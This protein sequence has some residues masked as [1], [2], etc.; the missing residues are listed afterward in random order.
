MENF[1]PT[2][3]MAPGGP[4][5]VPVSPGD[6]YTT[7]QLTSMSDA[8]SRKLMTV[9][10]SD[11]LSSAPN[12]STGTGDICFY[13]TS[14][15]EWVTLSDR[16]PVTTSFKAYILALF[17]R[18]VCPVMTP[19]VS[20]HG[21][22]GNFTS[23]INGFNTGTGSGHTAYNTSP[24]SIQVITSSPGTT[25]TGSFKGYPIPGVQ[26]AYTL[27]PV[28]SFGIV[29]SYRPASQAV[30][31]AGVDNWHWR[32]GLQTP[33]YT[34]SAA[35]QA[36][37]IG[38]VMDDQNALGLGA[39]GSTLWSV[40]RL[41]ST[42][43]LWVDSL[44]NPTSDSRFLIIT[45]EPTGPGARQCLFEVSSSPD[46]STITTHASQNGSFSTAVSNALLPM[47]TGAK[48]L[49]TASRFFARRGMMAFTYRRT[50][51]GGVLA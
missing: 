43:L 36:D 17:R 14:R 30:S 46:G 44:I 8:Q 22:D 37:E 13:N 49:G 45:C 40:V 31:I 38:F 35:L 19:V 18:G 28:R 11:C 4:L 16:V 33:L 3:P 39:T 12:A 5:E 24:T 50:T 2:L 23:E 1:I 9:W 20:A 7:G 26:A 41:D 15:R 48:T 47:I 42:T 27:D 21:D 10:C 51:G 25:S 6:Q 34:S 32:V 29:L